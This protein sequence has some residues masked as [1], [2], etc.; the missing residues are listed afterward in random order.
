MRTPRV[1]AR[2]VGLL[3]IHGGPRDARSQD[4]GTDRVT[5]IG[6]R[7]PGVGAKLG[8]RRRRLVPLLISVPL[9]GS[10]FALAATRLESAPVQTIDVAGNIVPAQ[11]MRLNFGV[12]GVVASIGVTP[13]QEVAAGTVLASLDTATL[14]A[15]MTQAR[16]AVDVAEA[17]LG[18]DAAASPSAEAVAAA[19]GALAS[20]QVQ[21]AAAQMGLID[22]QRLTQAIVAGAQLGERTGAAAVAVAQAQVDA[23]ATNL[24]DI[25]QFDGKTV[26]VAQQQVAAARAAGQAAVKAAQVQVNSAQKNVASVRGV[27]QKTVATAQSNLQGVTAVVQ[28]DQQAVSA[29]QSKLQGDTARTTSDCGATPS[30]TQCGLDQQVVVQDQQRLTAD[31][32]TLARDQA[33]ARTTQASVGQVQATAR[34]NEAQAQAEVDAATAALEGAQTA[35]GSAAAAAQTQLAQVQARARADDDQAAGQLQLARAVLADAQQSSVP[36]ARNALDQAR[37]KAQQSNNAARAQLQASQVQAQTAQSE[38]DALHSPPAV[39]LI[40]A[41]EDEIQSAQALVDLTAHQLSQATLVAPAHG[42]VDGISIFPGQKVDAPTAQT[43]AIV[44]H[45]PGSFQLTAPVRD[46]EISRVH[47]RDPVGVVAAGSTRTIGGSITSIA[48]LAT[49]QN[50]VATF[51]VTATFQADGVD[52]RPGMSARMSIL[53]RQAPGATAQPTPPAHPGPA[54]STTPPLPSNEASPAPTPFFGT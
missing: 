23:A 38:L 22:N 41:D 16:R 1:P 33:T 45:S 13:G 5:S 42:V 44:L 53:V 11:E 50:G 28:S 25:R 15:Q 43:Y 24:T 17:R 37:A 27:D 34:Q 46:A 32:Q 39:Q 9:V 47:L 26:T 40:T 20:A 8:L 7:R 12:P 35:Q 4:T 19:V 29:D 52:L 54:F 51:A 2:R 30:S 6:S 18:F 31:Q 21:V 48:P 14:D 3:S 49:I 36:V 10:M